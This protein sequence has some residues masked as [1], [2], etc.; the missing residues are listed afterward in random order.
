LGWNKVKLYFMIGLPTETYEDLKGIS[1]LANAVVDVYRQVNGHTKGLT[2]T[3]STSTFVPKPFTPFQW[4]SQIT[5]EEIYDRQ[6]FLKKLL[7][8]SKNITYRWHNGKLSFLEAVFSRGDRKLGKV[9]KIAQ[10]KGCKFDGWDE[11]FDLDKWLAAFK[12]ANVDPNFYAY[13]KRSETE[14]FPWEIIDAGV[15]RKFLLREL[16][17]AKNGETTPDCRI[18]CHGCGIKRLGD[19]FC[20]A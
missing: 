5:L 17:K 4:E 19:G 7:K 1:D 12:E 10:E 20:E 18:R 9:L 8:K 14:K 15:D 13:R 2:V 3:V 6:N 11:F 16:E